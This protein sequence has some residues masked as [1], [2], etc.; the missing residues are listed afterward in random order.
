MQ[1]LKHTVRAL[2]VNVGGERQ[3]RIAG[4]GALFAEITTSVNFGD[5]K[6]SARIRKI[7]PIRSPLKLDPS[8][9]SL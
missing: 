5:E 1:N 7:K 6:G 2:C 8:A 4:H 3:E 9:K